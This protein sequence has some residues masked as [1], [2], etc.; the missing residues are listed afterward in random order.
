MHVT[1][2]V[3]GA[4]GKDGST[5]RLN[6]CWEVRYAGTIRFFVMVRVR[7]YGTAFL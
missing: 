1:K 3:K 5:V 7:W 4:L 2:T 6:L